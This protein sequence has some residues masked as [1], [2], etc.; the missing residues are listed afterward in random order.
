VSSTITRFAKSVE[1]TIAPSKIAQSFA[2]AMTREELGDAESDQVFCPSVNCVCSV[3]VRRP[4]SVEHHTRAQDYHGAILLWPPQIVAR[5]FARRL[6]IYVASAADWQSAGFGP[7]FF[8]AFA[9]LH[10]QSVGP[11]SS[12]QKR[13]I[14]L[15]DKT[16]S[17]AA[18]RVLRNLFSAL[19]GQGSAGRGVF[20]QGDA[21]FAHLCCAV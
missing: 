13:V 5:L 17:G 14:G 15:P 11:P 1:L 8:L 16:S 19:A 20:K 12:C 4:P 2:Y 9:S 6:I 21:T 10:C 7:P 18:R 3:H